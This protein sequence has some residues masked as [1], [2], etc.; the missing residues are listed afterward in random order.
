MT[1]TSLPRVVLK[2]LKERSLQRMHP[3]VF[4]GAIK[5]LDEGIKEGDLV[6]VCDNQGQHLATGH[7]QASSLAVRLLR[8]GTGPID[9]E[10]WNER[11]SAAL[12]LRR[13]LGFWDSE[14]TN[15]WRLVHGEGDGLPGLVIDFYA[16]LAV[17]QCHS[18]GML[19]SLEPIS[20]ALRRALG[21]R[22]TGIY[23][24]SETTLPYPVTPAA[25]SG[26]LWGQAPD[27]VISE[28]GHRFA[29][30]YHEGQKTG[31][32]WTNERIGTWSKA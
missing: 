27:L 14:Q 28:H 31:F 18:L 26:L 7:Y 5:T 2:S 3:W 29:I 16:G 17:V 10:F 8:F 4:S 22:L 15:A 25:P 13:T 11:I 32:F 24:K 20:E 9:Q 6:E 1:I 12:N 19:H 30:D 21:G 23:N